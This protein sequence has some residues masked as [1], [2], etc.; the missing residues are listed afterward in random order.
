MGRRA[1]NDLASGLGPRY[2][3]FAI[4]ANVRNGRAFAD[5]LTAEPFDSISDHRGIPSDITPEAL[6]LGLTGDHSPTWVG[7]E[8]ILQF[9]WNRSTTKYGVVDA[10]EFEDWD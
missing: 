4:L 9:D 10:V 8:E 5:C 6:E 3:M 1:R 2:D 7:L